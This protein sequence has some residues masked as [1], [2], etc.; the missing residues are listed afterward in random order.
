V[1][2]AVNSRLLDCSDA[3]SLSNASD[4]DRIGKCFTWIKADTTF[5]GLLHAIKEYPKRVFIGDIAEKVSKVRASP[6]KYIA[7]IQIR[8]IAGSTL[9]EPWFDFSLPLNKDLLAIIGNKGSGKS[10]LADALGL[11]GD[12]RQSEHFSFLNPQKFRDPRNNKASHFD[13]VLTWE[14][15]K[16]ISRRLD[17]DPAINSVETIKYLPQNYIETLCNEI[18]AGGD[19]QFDLELREIIFSHVGQTDRLGHATL[20]NLLHYLTSETQATIRVLTERIHELNDR[21]VRLEEQAT[22]SFRAQLEAQLTAKREDLAVHEKSK[23]QAVPEPTQSAELKKVAAEIRSEIGNSKDT[24]NRLKTDLSKLI[25]EKGT[26]SRR[27]AVLDKAITKLDNFHLQWEELKRSLTSDLLELNEDPPI[28]FEQIAQLTINRG[29]LTDLR[30]K[31]VTRL[32]GIDTS[33]NPAIAGTPATEEAALEAKIA[34]LQDSL[35]EPNR[36]YVSYQNALEE[37]TKKRAAIQG[38]ANTF[39]SISWLEQRIAQ[40][41][42]VPAQIQ[43]LQDQRLAVS[44]SIYKEIK[45]LAESYRRLY[46]PVQ[47]FIERQKVSAGSIPLTFE[48][49]IVQEGFG[50]TFLE[51]VNRLVKGTFSGLEESNNLLRQML[52]AVEFDNEESVMAFIED[53]NACLH[54]DRRPSVQGQPAVQVK[55]QIRKGESPV[56]VYE[57]IYSLSYLTPRYTLHYG[58]RE[59]N[60]LSPGERGLLLLVFYLLIDNDDIP[61]VIDQPEENLDNQTIY[62]VLVRCLTDAKRRRQVVIV[63]HNPNLAVVCDAEQVIHARRDSETNSVHYETGAIENPTMNKHVINVLEGTRPAF[64]NRDSKYFVGR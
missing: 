35:D 25:V 8:K 30:K 57:Y 58:G 22:E 46:Q 36:R 59:I 14:S 31:I 44:R 48:V 7:Y 28:L 18:Q 5:E 21:I 23:L 41:A 42:N 60:Q 54:F 37:W 29:T 17:V 50:T 38:D 45:R 56:S 53:V 55:D 2:A 27:I 34:Q 62:E 51:K 1:K 49:S 63:T 15:G 13:C 39:Q 11:L 47:D 20:D 61:L 43:S 52:Q 3:H 40:L 12:T 26:A 9:A 24:L 33:L 4:K 16:Q 19:G 32:N 64:D 10:A 6:T